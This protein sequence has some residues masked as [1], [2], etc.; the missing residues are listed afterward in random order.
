MINVL[1][2]PNEENNKTYEIE[3][4]R[5][6]CIFECEKSDMHEG[7][8]GAY[9]V[10]CPVC[11]EEMFVE[12]VEGKPLDETN[13]QFPTHFFCMGENAVDI[14]DKQIQD[15]IRTG[16]AEVKKCNLD[17]WYTGTGNTMVFIFNQDDEYKIV[18]AKNYWDTDIF[19]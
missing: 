11:E 17:D 13:I 5:C 19:K 2:R 7:A 4:E 3:C 8:L 12:D 14:D 16:L 15:W 10:N 18:V 6:G 9:Y 1:Y